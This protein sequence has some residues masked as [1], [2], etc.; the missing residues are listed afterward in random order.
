MNIVS[1]SGGKDSTAML[2][3]MLEKGIAVDR[4]IF[5]DTT[6]EFPEIYRWIDEIERYTG[7][8]IERLKPGKTWDEHFYGA[9]TRGKY[10]G[11]RR[12]F[13]FVIQKCWWNREA[14]YLLLDKAHGSGNTVFI[15]IAKD[16]EKRTKARQYNKQ[17]IFY[18]FPLCEWGL[19]EQDCFDYLESKGL[20]HPLRHMKRTGCWLCQ[21]QSKLSLLILMREY[22]DLWEKLKKYEADSPHGFKPNFSLLDFENENL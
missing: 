18:R 13:P 5:A 11:E 10:K 9:F 20:F 21:K 6:L 1:F 8:P 15:G 4:I 16:E 3:K 2:L 19:T 12:G 22:P 14:K 7:I 17:H